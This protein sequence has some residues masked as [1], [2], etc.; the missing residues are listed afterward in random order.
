ME[1]ISFV[2][3]ILAA[4]VLG[5]II[6]AERQRRQRLAGMRT[7][8][9]VALGSAMFVSISLMLSPDT[10]PTRIAAQVVSGIGFLGAGLI[11]REGFNVQG[12]N[13][14]ATLWCSG[15]V[16]TLCG[17]GFI[18]E[19]FIG[20]TAVLLTHILLRPL[21][22]ILDKQRRTI[23]AKEEKAGEALYQIL[24]VC[25]NKDEQRLRSLLLHTVIQKGLSL[26]ALV[27]EDVSNDKLEIQAEIWVEQRDD[28]KLEEIVG[29]LSLEP[30]ISAISWKVIS[31]VS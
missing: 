29:T 6:G 25:R 3:Y 14:A 18:T 26:R 1:T 4:L 19:A 10:S 9:L 22:Q 28:R 30:S 5:A 11:V 24:V 27:S 2:R 17:V 21:G 20:T 31:D 15:A 16:G 8:A 23:I 13:T 12:L 7:N